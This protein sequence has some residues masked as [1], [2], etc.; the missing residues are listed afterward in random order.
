VLV[1]TPTLHQRPSASAGSFQKQVTITTV[2]RADRATGLSNCNNYNTTC[3]CLLNLR[4]AYDFFFPD[5]R[6]ILL[7][8][9]Q[10]E[11]STPVKFRSW[12]CQLSNMVIVCAKENG[13]GTRLP[14]N[15]FMHKLKLGM[16]HMH[17]SA[18]RGESWDGWPLVPIMG[19]CHEIEWE[20]KIITYDVLASAAI[21]ISD[22]VAKHLVQLYGC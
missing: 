5:S 14:A 7:P 19:T 17:I 15:Y 9:Q 3:L 4:D 10:I 21:L 1:A 20:A 12:M 11:L 22:G 6:L 13:R 8:R 18:V 2:H 16:L